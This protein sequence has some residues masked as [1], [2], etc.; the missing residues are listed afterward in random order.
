MMAI[1]IRHNLRT[2]ISNS[3]STTTTN[4]DNRI[5]ITQTK[6]RFNTHREFK[7]K[8]GI[9][10]LNILRNTRIRIIAKEVARRME[11]YHLTLIIVGQS[12]FQMDLLLNGQENLHLYLN[13][14]SIRTHLI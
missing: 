9:T 5:I 14:Q 13:M 1:I 4:R 3:N 8:S 7:I 10:G 11:V 12:L 2:T 6:N